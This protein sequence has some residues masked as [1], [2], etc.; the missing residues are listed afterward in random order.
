MAKIV[1]FYIPSNFRHRDNER[2][3]RQER[4]KVIAFSVP[5]KKSA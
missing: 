4:G 5:P 2:I 1:G 3:T